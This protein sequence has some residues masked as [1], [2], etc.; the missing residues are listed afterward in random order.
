M[1]LVVLNFRFLRLLELTVLLPP[2]TDDRLP[3]VLEDKRKR[4]SHVNDTEPGPVVWPR[5]DHARYQVLSSR[6]RRR[7]TSKPVL[8]SL[9]NTALNLYSV[10]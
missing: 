4:R 8:Y 1:I 6:H 5:G 3:G 2:G 7:G 10:S 9:H